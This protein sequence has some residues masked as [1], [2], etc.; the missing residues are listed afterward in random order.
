VGPK[1]SPCA[2]DPEKIRCAFCDAE[3][4]SKLI[5]FGDVAL[6]RSSLKEGDFVAEPKFRLRA[7]TTESFGKVDNPQELLPY[8]Q[9][10]VLKNLWS[11]KSRMT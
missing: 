10:V 7:A 9:I 8:R 1:E 6:A 4:L 3:D 11:C 5:D 2:M